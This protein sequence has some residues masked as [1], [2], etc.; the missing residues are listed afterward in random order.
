MDADEK[1]IQ[2]IEQDARCCGDQIE[3][4]YVQT[5]VLCEIARQLARLADAYEGAHS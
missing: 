1:R 4:A 5:M 2:K 3:R